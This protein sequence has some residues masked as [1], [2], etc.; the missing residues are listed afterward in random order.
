MIGKGVLCSPG[1]AL[2]PWQ[3][4]LMFRSLG[5]AGVPQERFRSCGMQVLSS[6]QSQ[7]TCWSPETVNNLRSYSWAAA[8][9]QLPRSAIGFQ[10]ET[11]CI[12]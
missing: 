1:R 10:N 11:V 2:A 9:L 12:L 3:H 8:M 6:L 7:C 5:R 4:S